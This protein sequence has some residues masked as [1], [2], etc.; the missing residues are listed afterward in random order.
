MGVIP[1]ACPACKGP[2]E[3]AASAYRCGRCRNDYPILCG[4]PDF[5]ILPDRYISIE[6][7]RRKGERLFAE[8]SRRSFR[9]MLDF[10][11][12][13]TPEV[14]S[15]LARK[16]TAH[17]LVEAA[18]GEQVLA[19]IGESPPD[20]PLLDV[21]CS[22][23]GLLVA[24]AGRRLAPLVGVDV[25]FRWLVIGTARLR[26]A[27]VQAQLVCANAELLPFPCG[28]FTV[29]TATDLI[30]HVAEPAR[31]FAE[32]YRVAAARGT[33]YIAT[34]NR[35]SLAPEPHTGI[36]GV[37]W[38][39]RALQA[40]YVRFVSGRAYRNIVLRSARELEEWARKAGFRDCS[41]APAPLAGRVS[42]S[43]WF[44]PVEK[45]YNRLRRAP[46]SSGLLRW[47]GPRLQLLCRK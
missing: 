20:G 10:Y 17:A 27:G 29:I 14:P 47:I 2:V 5:R 30:E 18:I 40:G 8:T 16:F 34:N 3:L 22:T 12:S 26:E 19:Q 13:I 24:A 43:R 31:V 25:A 42:N 4:I 33:V 46:G 39:P 28:R 6:D 21:G 37:G 15:A 38:W 9:E 1:F 32:C 11:Y 7:D 35:F 41:A 44:A 23:G 45:L 36:W